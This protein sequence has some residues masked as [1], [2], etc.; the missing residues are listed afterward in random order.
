MVVRRAVRLAPWGG[1]HRV[2][3]DKACKIALFAALKKPG[4]DTFL[5]LEGATVV[6]SFASLKAALEFKTK[7]ASRSA[8]IV[9]DH[10]EFDPARVF[11]DHGSAFG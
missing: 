8:R 11:T 5:V 4:T 3:L 1:P 10:G 6:G 7:S 2:K 9:A